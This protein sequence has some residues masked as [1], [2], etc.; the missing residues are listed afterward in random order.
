MK[1]GDGRESG[2]GREGKSDEKLLHVSSY[3]TE[4]L[5]SFVRVFFIFQQIVRK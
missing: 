1:R 2:N 5:F 4:K 3:K